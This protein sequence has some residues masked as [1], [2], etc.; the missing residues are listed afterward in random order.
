M[1]V[2]TL[3][4][5]YGYLFLLGGTLVEGESFLVAAAVLAHQGYLEMEWIIPT[6]FIGGFMADQCCFY[7]GRTRGMA[8]LEKRH[9][10]QV[11][12][13]KV[14]GLM[15]RFDH[16]LV[17]GLHFT[18]GLRSVMAF[19]IGASGFTPLKFCLLNAIGVMAWAATVGWL[20]YQF[21]YLVV[22]FLEE[23]KQYQV[24]FLIVFA[25]MAL[26]FWIIRRVL[27]RRARR[28]P[29]ESPPLP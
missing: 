25:G 29:P 22:T 4:K 21:G 16:A 8:L 27:R 14:F 19:V 1:D 18:Y 13:R 12:A 2:E 5:T 23:A 26:S 17:L 15:R 28:I 9:K 7:L 11:K 3:I 24:F 6:A 10:W 20:G